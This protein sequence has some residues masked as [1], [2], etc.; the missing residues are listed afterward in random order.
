MITKHVI[1]CSHHMGWIVE[2]GKNSH[3]IKMSMKIF[4]HPGH[5]IQGGLNRGQLDL[6]EE[7][8]LTDWWGVSGI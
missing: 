8:V 1:P 4:S 6:V 7:S 2:M 3:V 5:V